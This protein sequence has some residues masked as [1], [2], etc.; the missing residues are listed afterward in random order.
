MSDDAP[1]TSL[2]VSADFYR[3]LCENAA[4]ALIATDAAFNIVTWNQAASQLLGP[5][6]QEMFGKHIMQAVPSARRKLMQR[7]LRRTTERGETSQFEVRM[8][9]ADKQERFLM[10]VLSPIPGPEGASQGVAAWIVDETQQKKLGDRLSQAEKMA[11]LGTLAGGV[12]HHFN[13]IL[14]GVATFVDFALT[15]GDPVAM[16]R[17]L[18]MTAEAAARAAKITQ[19]LLSFAEHKT[20]RSDLAD[21][22]EV[23]LTFV[24]L[25]E[26]P[27]AEH[28]IDLHLDLRPV[29]VVAVEA[30]RMHQVLGNLLTNAEEA[31]P[32]G[33]TISITINRQGPEV[34]MTFGDTGSGIRPEHLGL[35]FEPFFTTKGLLAGGERANP[36]LGLSVVHG[37][38]VEMGGRIE[39]QSESGKGA[40][41]VISFPIAAKP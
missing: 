30:N 2:P 21:L 19:S 31:M 16:K 32:E 40:K 41:F 7:L 33:G 20:G 35:V 3:R 8:E 5:S 11:S 17:A 28:K 10:V 12:A 26:R 9:G 1:K 38:I 29:P 6:A 37:I 24:H 39:A 4:V 23:V 18:H 13:N 22:T 34:V 27:L 25:V 14:G 36:G 15:S